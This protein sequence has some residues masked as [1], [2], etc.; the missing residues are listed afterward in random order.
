MNSS[1]KQLN[2][3]IVQELRLNCSKFKQS[4]TFWGKKLLTLAQLQAVG[5]NMQSDT[6]NK[7]ERKTKPISFL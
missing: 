5:H 4:T 7:K 1:K 6:R 3:T 2:K